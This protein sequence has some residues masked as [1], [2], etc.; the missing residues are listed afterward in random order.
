MFSLI[1]WF[2]ILLIHLFYLSY[3]ALGIRILKSEM[4]EQNLYEEYLYGSES[5]YSNYTLNTVNS[6]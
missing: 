6:I 4:Q 3:C 5:Q 1:Y 2:S